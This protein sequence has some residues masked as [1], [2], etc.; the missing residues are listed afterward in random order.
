MRLLIAAVGKLKDG[1]E[2]ELYAR[3]A[4]RLGTV[5][6]QL[7]L[8]PIDIIELPESR[9]GS[10]PERQADEAARLLKAASRSEVIVALHETGRAYSSVAFAGLLRKSRDQGCLH[11][12]L[13]SLAAKRRQRADAGDGPAA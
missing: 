5:S 11:A 13:E 8:G 1:G 2:R 12:A 7:A 10:S 3:Y 9:A 6:R 4:G